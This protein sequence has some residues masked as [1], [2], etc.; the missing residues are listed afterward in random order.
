[1]S[2][3]YDMAR[4]IR[5]RALERIAVLSAASSTTTFDKS[6]LERLCRAAPSHG[7]IREN[8]NGHVPGRSAG[9][10]RIPMVRERKGMLLC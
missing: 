7:K 1:V 8:G 10:G 9:V 5:Q 2:P 3:K 6:D 4:D